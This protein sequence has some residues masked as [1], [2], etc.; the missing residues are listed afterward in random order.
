M[1]YCCEFLNEL[2]YCKNKEK[3][4]ESKPVV[5]YHFHYKQRDLKRDVEIRINEFII[6]RICVKKVD[7]CN[8][9]RDGEQVK[10]GDDVDGSF[11]VV[12]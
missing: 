10:G 4:P 1:R 12:Y 8:V 11:R 9:R 2:N 7:E 6:R 5:K 3:T